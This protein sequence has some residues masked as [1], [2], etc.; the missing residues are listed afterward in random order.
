MTNQVNARASYL[1]SCILIGA[2]APAAAFDVGPLTITGF[3]KVEFGKTSNICTDCQVNPDPDR[4]RPWADAITPGK[5]YGTDDGN[6]TL[7]Q[8]YIG[9]K[10]FSLGKG[11]RIKGL[12]SQRWRDGKVDIPGVV[13]EQNATVL[14]EDYGMLQVGAFPTRG[15]S[16]GDYPYGT[17]IGVADAWASSG[18][19]YGLLANAVR[20]SLPKMDVRNGDLYLEA[21]VDKGDSPSTQYKPLFMELYAQYVK[22]PWV[23]DMVAQDAKNGAPSAWSHGPFRGIANT[24]SDDRLVN[25]GNRQRILMLMGRYQYNAK[26]VL[27]GGVRKNDWSGARATCT[28]TVPGTTNCYY[29]PFFNV[30]GVGP[31]D[32][33]YSAR[34]T[35]FSLGATYRIDA[36]WSLSAGMVHLGKA[37]TSNPEERG[38]SN[39]MTLNTVGVGYD[40]KPGFNV[41]AFTGMVNYGHKGLAPLSMPS[42]SA[43]S[44]VDS[45]VTK[46]GNWAGLGA[47]YTW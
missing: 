19:G 47:V 20:Y 11:W 22:G 32:K 5:T 28:G 23:W 37:K 33:A 2:S 14:H 17:Q 9:T 38:Q 41:Y 13:Y 44:G 39:S 10:E 35:D 21:S 36:K 27:F 34:S 12:Y 16:V 26:T 3:A 18:S 45:R 29:A 4:Q 1:V 30:D 42:H 24:A 15:W 7:F 31:T 43:F 8:P 40:V 6:T 25:D 46:S